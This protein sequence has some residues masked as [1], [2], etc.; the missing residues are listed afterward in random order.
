MLKEP[1]KLHQTAFSERA[2]GKLKSGD[3]PSEKAK[4]PKPQNCVMRPPAVPS[5]EIECEAEDK[6]ADTSTRSNQRP[7]NFFDEAEL[8]GEL[9]ED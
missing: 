3:L 2:L 6:C 7:L 9:E 5:N 4:W 8:E 1:C